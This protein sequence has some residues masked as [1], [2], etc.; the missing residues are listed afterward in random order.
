MGINRHTG[1]INFRERENIMKRF[2]IEL[3][4]GYREELAES[5]EEI[6]KQYENV[7]TLV[8]IREKDADEE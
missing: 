2:E 6:K 4:D 5:L 8:N 7:T 1:I 3:M